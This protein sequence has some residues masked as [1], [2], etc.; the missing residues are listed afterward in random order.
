MTPAS[1]VRRGRLL[2]YDG[3]LPVVDPTA[4]VADDATLVGAVTLGP[5]VSVWYG[6]VIRADGDVIEIGSGSNVQDGCVLHS[7][8]DH[9]VRVGTDVTLGHRAVV[10][11]CTVEDGALVGMGAV[12]LNGARIGS[13]SLIAAGSVVLEGTEI[14]PGSLVAGVPGKVRRPVTDQERAR[15]SA[16]AASYVARAARYAN[17]EVSGDEE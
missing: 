2:P 6:T 1:G 13:G 8:P 11:G 14:E 9:P 7:D 5:R 17:I 10:H 4:W 3:T 15:M 12:V 16:G